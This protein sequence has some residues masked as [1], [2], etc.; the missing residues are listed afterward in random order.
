VDIKLRELVEDDR[1][2]VVWRIHKRSVRC[3]PIVAPGS[4]VQRTGL[5]LGLYIIACRLQ[6]IAYRENNV[7]YRAN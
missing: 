7:G 3:R 4:A 2:T 6:S 1:S 5:G